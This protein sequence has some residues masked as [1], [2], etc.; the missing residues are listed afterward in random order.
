MF[1]LVRSSSFSWLCN[2]SRKNGESW[3]HSVNSNGNKPMLNGCPQF[4]LYILVILIVS[5][6][7]T[8]C[9]SRLLWSAFTQ[10][11][12][13]FSYR[14]FF[15]RGKW[16]AST[17]VIRPGFERRRA[18]TAEL[19]EKEDHDVRGCYQTRECGDWAIEVFIHWG[20]IRPFMNARL[21]STGNMFSGSRRM[22]TPNDFF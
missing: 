12:P 15:T 10:A 2:E 6:K 9:E 11:S 18:R 5:S 3:R 20:L 22:K 7:S 1:W 16:L 19:P 8:T 4:T 14:L 21:T 17:H 13:T